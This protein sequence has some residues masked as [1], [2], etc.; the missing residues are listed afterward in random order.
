M[1]IQIGD[2]FGDYQVTGVLGRGG[3]G[4]VYRVRSLLTDRE[5]A[6]KVVLN[7]DPALAD[8]FLREI[9]VHAS[10]QH[11]NIAALH[12]ALRIEQRIVMILELV[13]GVSL[14]ETLR[15]GP[16][17]APVA[18]HYINQVLGALAFAHGRGVIHRDVKP[19]NILIAS[20][21]VVKLTDFGMARSA[22]G[23]QLT[24]AGIAVGTLAYMSPEQI[25]SGQVDARSDIYSL[26]L[27]CYE[28]V[29]GRRA[30]DARRAFMDA[31]IDAI[32]PGPAAV[33]PLVPQALSAAIMRA[34]AKEPAQRFQTALEFR[35]ALPD[36]GRPPSQAE[37]TPRAAA[38]T[39]LELADL[40]ARLVR[41]IGPTAR[42]LVA[43]AAR[44][45]STLAEIQHA[46]AS[47][48]EDPRQRDA[49]RKANPGATVTMVAIPATSPISF[50]PAALGRVAQALAT[51]IGPT[52]EAVVYRAART[53]PSAEELRNVLAAAI[54]SA[55]DRQR[56]LA[57]VRSFL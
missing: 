16:I 53:A 21:G 6:M 55:A 57:T 27:T 2:I 1:P 17:E 34:L 22:G 48:I 46:L 45:Y 24:K 56:F 20:G 28:M 5:E 35:A 15:R 26:G 54:P 37:V 36:I 52:A 13:E 44:R 14:E 4:E 33:N 32:P 43:D 29:T 10:L 40:E 31:Q 50:D 49:F 18:V 3:M 12:A 42:G 41:A 9:K 23:Q 11:P 8:R 38:P 47:G 7:E 39:P 30:G 51:Y 25:R 19:A